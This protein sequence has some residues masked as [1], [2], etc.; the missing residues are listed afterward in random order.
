MAL[1]IM[2]PVAEKLGQQFD[3]WSFA[4]TRARARELKQRLEK[5]RVFYL[6]M[7]QAVAVEFREP[8]EDIPNSR[9][10]AGA[11]GLAAPY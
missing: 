9:F 6:R 1:A 10:R 3:V 11:A 8:E 2:Q 7:R 4:A 5:L